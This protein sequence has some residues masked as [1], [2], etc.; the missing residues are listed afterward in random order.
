RYQPDQPDQPVS[1]AAKFGAD[2][3][4]AR[5]RMALEHGHPVDALGDAPLHTL[6]DEMGDD[7]DED[8]EQ[9]SWPPFDQLVLPVSGR[10][11]SPIH[12]LSPIHRQIAGPSLAA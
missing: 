10:S 11:V 5:L 9:D 4:T 7:E 6:G 8:R 2:R 3:F 1:K 12:I